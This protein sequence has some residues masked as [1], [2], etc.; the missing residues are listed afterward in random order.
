MAVKLSTQF[1]LP[2]AQSTPGRILNMSF[3]T[4]SLLHK[5]LNYDTWQEVIIQE[6]ALNFWPSAALKGDAICP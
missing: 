3:W 5:T 6:Q 2:K 4:Q 1:T